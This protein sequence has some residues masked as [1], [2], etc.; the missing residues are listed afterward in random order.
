MG[1]GS[2]HVAIRQFVSLLG[3]GKN[4]QLSREFMPDFPGKYLKQKQF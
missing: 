3:P 2:V 1:L 4:Q